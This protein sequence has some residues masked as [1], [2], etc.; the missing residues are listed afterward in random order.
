MKIRRAAL[1]KMGEHT[2]RNGAPMAMV[3]EPLVPIFMYHRYSVESTASMLGGLDY[4]YGMRGDGRTAVKWESAANQRKALDALAGTLKPAE[5]TVPK[6][7]LDLIPPRPPGYG[8]HRELFPHQIETGHELG[9][10]MLNLQTRV[11]FQKIELARCIGQQKLDRT[12]PGVVH[13]ACYLHGLVAH[14]PPQAGIVYRRG[15]LFDHFLVPPLNRTLTLAEMDHVAVIVGE[16]LDLDVTWTF[17][18]FLEIERRVSEGRRC[19]RLRGLERGTKLARVPN[20]PHS[21]T[22]A[23]RGGFQHHWIAEFPGAL[24]RVT[25]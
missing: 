9:N 22:A 4:I 23:A 7:I 19:F 10:R 13:R 2:I 20:E 5:L 12:R 11:H 21:F 1:S 18:R 25:K 14:A 16:D 24:I 6:Q 3:E 15:T 8:R 17:D